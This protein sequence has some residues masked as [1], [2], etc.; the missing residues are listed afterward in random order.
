MNRLIALVL[1][2]TSLSLATTASA[3]PLKTNYEVSQ[4]FTQ[5]SL[6]GN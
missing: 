6:N 1:L 4:F 2:A 5:Q 3:G